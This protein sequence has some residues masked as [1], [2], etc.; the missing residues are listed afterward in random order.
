ML[1]QN[2]AGETTSAE[3]E[4]TDYDFLLIKSEPSNDDPNMSIIGTADVTWDATN[5]SYPV[6]GSVEINSQTLSKGDLLIVAM[7]GVENI[8]TTSY[9]FHTH[10]II[11]D[12]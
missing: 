3:L 6:T 8:T 10:T 1:H 2:G 11:L 7:H 9:I 5:T 12:K 4:G